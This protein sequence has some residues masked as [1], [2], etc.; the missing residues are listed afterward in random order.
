MQGVGERQTE[1]GPR[2]RRFAAGYRG[3]SRNARF[4]IGASFLASAV[5]GLLF[6]NFNL[7]LS[8]RGFDPASCS[9]AEAIGI[10]RSAR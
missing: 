5:Y 8:A 7:Y 2:L 9:G 3:F 4:F 1:I 10:A 6:V